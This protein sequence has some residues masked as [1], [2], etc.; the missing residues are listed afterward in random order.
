MQ[1]PIILTKD[2]QTK[3]VPVGYSVTSFFFGLFVPLL[4]G[5]FAAAGALFLL[6]LISFVAWPLALLAWFMPPLYNRF[7]ISRLLRDGWKY[8][9]AEQ[10]RVMT[11]GLTQTS[12]FPMQGDELRNTLMQIAAFVVLFVIFFAAGCAGTALMM[13]AY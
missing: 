4:R 10:E 11:L 8:S 13:S 3:T 1:N 12:L 5:D 6:V 9:E 7:Y 2:N